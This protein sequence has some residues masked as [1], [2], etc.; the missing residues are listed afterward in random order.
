MKLRLLLLIFLTSIRFN[1]LLAAPPDY[2]QTKDGIIVFT[3]AV[4][5]GTCNAV[6]LEVISDNIIRVI[7]A[8][9]KEFKATQSL[10]TVYTKQTG[11][12][13]KIFPSKEFLTLKQKEY[14]Q[15]LT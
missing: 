10:I 6:K 1:V 11:V 8:P 15:L 4:F 12:F 14:R 5:T 13:W 9:G 3:D 7:A 2:I